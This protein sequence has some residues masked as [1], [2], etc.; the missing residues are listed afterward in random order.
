VPVVLVIGGVA[1]PQPGFAE[2]FNPLIALFFGSFVL[3][4]GVKKVGL[5]RLLARWIVAR[6]GRGPRSLFAALLGTSA[7]LS[8]WMSNTGSSIVLMPIVL[9]VTATLG[10]GYRRAAVLGVAYAATIGGVATIVGTPTNAIAVDLIESFTGRT[11]G[12][13]EWIAFGLPL[14]L[15]LLPAMGA[16]LWWRSDIAVDRETFDDT[17]FQAQ[18]ELTERAPLS[19]DQWIVIAV[20]G[21]GRAVAAM[22]GECVCLPRRCLRALS[23]PC[24]PTS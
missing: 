22:R 23:T 7:I 5:D 3:A 8:M 12:F 6:L 15:L 4:E 21:G 24:V 11:I 13:A 9:A 14:A 20:F 19:R 18:L 1:E 16:Y 10:D 17:R 2:F